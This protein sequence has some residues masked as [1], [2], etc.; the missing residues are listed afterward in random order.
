MDTVHD[1]NRQAAGPELHS[2]GCAYEV[3]PG[4]E[5]AEGYCV[6]NVEEPEAAVSGYLRADF[7][8]AGKGA[9]RAGFLEP[10][11]HRRLAR[12]GTKDSR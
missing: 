11:S 7:E 3:G 4:P 8:A 5:S 12:A 10:N 9:S 1:A 2:P 6:E